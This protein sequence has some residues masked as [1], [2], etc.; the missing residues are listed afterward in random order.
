MF[1]WMRL[2]LFDIIRDKSTLFF[3]VIFPIVMVFILGN[4]LSSL[5]NPDSPIGTIRIAVYTDEAPVQATQ[6]DGSSVLQGGGQGDEALSEAEVSAIQGDGSSVLPDGGQG[7]KAQS[8]A[9][10]SATQGDGSSVLPDGGQGGEALSGAGT[11]GPGGVYDAELIERFAEAQA[12]SSFGDG[13]A[14]SDGVE[15]VKA[16]TPETA[17]AAATARDGESLADTAMIFH[18]PLSIEI[19][20]GED[21]YKNRATELIAQSFARQYAAVK[22]AA[23]HSPEFYAELTQN[24]MPAADGLV[25]DKDLGVSRT[26]MDYYAVTMIVM[27]IFMGGGIGGASQ[28]YLSRQDGSLR[29]MTASPRSRARLFIESVIGALP[30]S[31]IQAGIVMALSTTL[32]GAHYAAAWQDNLLLFVYFII[33]SIAVTAVFMVVGLFVKINPY[34]PILVVMWALLFM[35]GTFNKESTI[36]GFTEYLPMNI[37]QRAAFDLTVFGRSDQVL[38]VMA[39]SGIVIVVT[40]A[41]GSLLYRRKETMF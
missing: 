10:V 31:V 36:P 4:M 9:E 38:L 27:I 12:V 19:T 14:D 13:L 25:E 29:R 23:F 22:T 40:C 7:G 21:I 6:G 33:L 18:T 35:A 30:Q 20:E 16:E 37:A 34:I 11:F 32:M 17:R 26:M 1:D 24:G 28:T 5:D 2:N 3:M 39:V 15:I 8:G 41:I